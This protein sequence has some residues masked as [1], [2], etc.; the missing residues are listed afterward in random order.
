MVLDPNVAQTKAFFQ[1]LGDEI[2]QNNEDGPP[3]HITIT[4]GDIL[5]A[6]IRI[7]RPQSDPV[8]ESDGSEKDGTDEADS[9]EQGATDA[10][11]K[12]QENG[13]KKPKKAKK[14]TKKRQK[15]PPARDFHMKVTTGRVS[16]RFDRPTQAHPPRGLKNFGNTC[17]QNALYQCLIHL[18]EFNEYILNHSCNEKTDPCVACALRSLVTAYWHGN[19]LRGMTGPETQAKDLYEAVRTAL[20]Q[21][22][23]ANAKLLGKVRPNKE[24]ALEKSRL[25]GLP[26]ALFHVDMWNRRQCD[27]FEFFQH[28]LREL[29]NSELDP[30]ASTFNTA[31]NITG[32][33]VWTCD[34][35]K[36]VTS[37]AIQSSEMGHGIGIA[38]N[39]RQPKPNLD[40]TAYLRGNAFVDPDE[41]TIRCESAYCSEHFP[42]YDPKEMHLPEKERK[43]NE[44]KPRKRTKVVTHFPE[45]L[46][47]RL[48]RYELEKNTRK[49][50][51]EEVKV[52]NHVD[53]DEYINL[54]EFAPA[55][56]GDDDDKDEEQEPV[57]YK[58]QGV[59]AHYG[60]TLKA[61]HY[62]A[63]VRH[64]DGRNFS[65]VNDDKSVRQNNGGTAQEAR[66]PSTTDGVG[67]NSTELFDPYLLFYSKL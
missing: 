1:K 48:Q 32:N 64:A 42:K 56:A 9:D 37:T 31:L 13:G 33:R 26:D 52:S 11:G 67:K 54:G 27:P 21:E 57:M 12:D 4:K 8:D 49:G 10:V 25:A 66:W 6:N 60:D 51:Q 38:V 7:G 14:K 47:I 41:L 22:T 35:C 16:K 23:A 15:A 5:K 61:G 20:P 58:L 53:F 63:A 46:V 62:V 17:Y 19:G 55:P 24:Q 43:V 65:I 18:P 59:V 44:G 28:L 40:L 36:T 45:V 3:L 30:V 39:L 50:T 29:D 2:L 34:D